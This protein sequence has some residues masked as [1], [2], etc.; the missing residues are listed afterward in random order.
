M[1]RLNFFATFAEQMVKLGS[2]YL[3]IASG[4]L[5]LMLFVGYSASITIFSHKHMVD[6]IAVVHSHFY[7]GSAETPQHNHTPQQFS[8]IS[9]L[10]LFVSLSA[11]MVLF[12]FTV[13]RISHKI[14]TIYHFHSEQSASRWISLRA[15][16]T[17][18]L[19]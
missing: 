2:K 9:A 5:M 7:S 14:E 6:G 13:N 11:S 18:V 19:N 3:H 15:P 16:P 8:T 10:S 1:L 12:S 4:F 17:F